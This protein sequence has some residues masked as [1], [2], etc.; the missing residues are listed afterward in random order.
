MQYE[1]KGDNLPAVICRLEAGETM[2]TEGGGMS[3]MTPNMRM[4]TTSAGGAKK[5]LGRLVSGESLF[6]NRYTSDG[7]PGLIAF[8]SSFPG[9]IIPFEISPGNEIVL[10][11]SA[12]LASEAS[13][14][15]STF[16]NKKVKGG[17]FSGEGFIMQKV[18][19]NGMVFGEF[20]GSVVEYELKAG[21]QMIVETGH[22]AAMSAS[23]TIDTVTIKGAKNIM[24]GGEGLFNTVVTGPGHIWLQTMP[25]PILA[26]KIQPF[27]RTT[28]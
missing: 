8:S 25:L 20:D 5:A 22:L 4:E 3:W 15:L 26:S 11:K 1:I 27:I 14:T 7:G 16:F 24:F 21:Q 13:V 2:I 6:M 19:G 17:L 9:R 12:F 23:C 28:E 18:S 10:E